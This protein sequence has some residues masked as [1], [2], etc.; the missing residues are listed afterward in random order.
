MKI[1][2]VGIAYKVTEEILVHEVFGIGR[3]NVESLAC[4]E[5]GFSNET[6]T[7]GSFESP[8]FKI[9]PS[10]YLEKRLELFKKALDKMEVKTLLQ[11]MRSMFLVDSHYIENQISLLVMAAL[12]RR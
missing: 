4:T 2:T 10:S 5:D 7:N 9:D 3:Y 1:D 6:C 12:V 11:Y 8:Q